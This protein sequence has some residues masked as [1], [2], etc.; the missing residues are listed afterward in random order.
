MRFILIM[1][2]KTLI[3]QLQNSVSTPDIDTIEAIETMNKEILHIVHCPHECLWATT[4]YTSNILYSKTLIIAG[5]KT[6]FLIVKCPVCN[7]ALPDRF[8]SIAEIDR[9]NE[10]GCI[11]CDTVFKINPNKDVY[12]YVYYEKTKGDLL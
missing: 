12:I 4:N 5:V 6:V 11:S 10:Y 1:S 2:T 9:E 8:Y 7:H 3:Q